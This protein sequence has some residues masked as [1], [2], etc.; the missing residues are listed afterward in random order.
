MWHEGQ[1]GATE[2]GTVYKWWTKV[3]DEPS[4]EFGL[5]GSRVSKLTI[6]KIGD[7]RDLFNYD[8]GLDKDAEN[9]EVAAVV[10]LVLA[11]FN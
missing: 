5:N 10:A 6:R 2:S 1:I 11:K 7:S 9:D 3:Y 8:R 4:E